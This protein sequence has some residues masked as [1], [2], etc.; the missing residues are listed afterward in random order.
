MAG[1]GEG[2]GAGCVLDASLQ[3]DDGGGC[4]P[5]VLP[6]LLDLVQKLHAAD[7]EDRALQQR[8]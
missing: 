8:P 7:R 5:R 3:E 4:G 1:R 2:R 6:G